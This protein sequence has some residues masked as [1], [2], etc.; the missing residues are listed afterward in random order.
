VISNTGYR[1]RGAQHNST[2]TAASGW[3]IRWAEAAA[4]GDGAPACPGET[5]AECVAAP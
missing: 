3:L 1:F 4:A 5:I 2:A